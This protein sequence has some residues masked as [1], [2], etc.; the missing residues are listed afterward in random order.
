[1]TK[2]KTS[3]NEVLLARR[4][5]LQ[6]LAATAAAGSGMLPSLAF[7]EGAYAD[8][9]ASNVDKVN[10]VV[11]QYGNIYE[12]VAAKFEADWGVPVEKII[13]PNIEPQIAKLTTMFAA[14]EDIDVFVSVL[15]TMASYIDQGI[16]AP[17]NGLPGVDDYIADMTPLARSTATIDGKLWGLPYLSIAWAFAYN[18]ELVEK[19][20]FGGMPFKTWDELTEQCLKA[21]ADGVSKYPLLWVGGPALETLPGTWF[22][23]VCNRGGRLFD[24]NM[25][26]EMGPGSIAREALQYFQDS[27]LKHE[28]ADPDSLNLK[29][30]PAVKV[31]NTGNHLYLGTFHDYFMNQL[32]DPAQS[33]IAG[34]VKVHPLP[35][36][37]ATLAVTWYY[38]MSEAT[39]DREW[40]WKMLQYLGGKTKDGAYTQ[41]VSLAKSSMLYPGYKSVAE[42]AEIREAWSSR[43]DVDVLQGIYAKGVN[44]EKVVP[45]VTQPW[46]FKWNE[47]LNLE[48]TACL[49]GEITP[50]V[51]CDNI[52][53]AVEKAKG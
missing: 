4:N 16:A 14:G 21:K 18:E 3:L 39:R 38:M 1:M 20:G 5:F 17:L 33:P 52:V 12:K 47:L 28:I 27:F 42:S 29:F 25:N 23:M 46:Y 50:D 2:I 41:A 19:A 22:S 32:N 44:Y 53:A 43:V 26:P 34:K 31:F 51:A 30:L 11:W 6:A 24:E 37:G 40:A 45:A 35:G 13:E 7:A 15:S 36:D 9:P 10:L 48:L 8:R 49:K